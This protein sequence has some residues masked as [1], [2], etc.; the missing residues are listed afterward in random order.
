MELVEPET[1]WG[2]A[3]KLLGSIKWDGI[4]GEETSGLVE[5]KS[6]RSILVRLCKSSTWKD[7]ETTKENK[8]AR[9][10]TRKNGNREIKG[11]AR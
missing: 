2:I 7:Q 6:L 9:A 4:L 1:I 3:E 11:R 10:K 8:P 5:I